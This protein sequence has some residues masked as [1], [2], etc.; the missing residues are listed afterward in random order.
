MERLVGKRDP[1][2]SPQLVDVALGLD[3]EERPPASR[4]DVR[5]PD[6]SN[7][8]EQAVERGLMGGA[9]RS[10]SIEESHRSRNGSSRSG[11]S[12]RS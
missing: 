11:A 2:Q 5:D 1:Q 3:H 4:V 10:G 7:A 12:Y 6:A 9:N 8:V